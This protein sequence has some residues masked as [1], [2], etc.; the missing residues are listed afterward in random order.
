MT[1]KQHRRITPSLVLSVL[2]LVVAT[3]GTGVAATGLITGQQIKDGTINLR[4]LSPAARRA[5][6][7]RIGPQGP[8][9]PQG[10]QGPQGPAGKDGASFYCTGTD[11]IVCHLVG[12]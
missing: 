3:T 4:D 12:P 10:A 11:P 5:L 7:G 1:H 9:G 2:A 8:A 6:A